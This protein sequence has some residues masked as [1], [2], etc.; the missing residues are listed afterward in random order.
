MT[1]T[2][3]AAPPTTMVYRR[4]WLYLIIG[5]VV[6]F[7]IGYKTYAASSGGPTGD[8]VRPDTSMFTSGVTMQQCQRACPTC[9]WQQS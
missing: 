8:C 7:V 9:R 2:P 4:C 3:G 6:G 1:G 5:L